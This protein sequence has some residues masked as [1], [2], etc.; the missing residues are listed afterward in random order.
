MRKPLLLCCAALLC[1]TPAAVLASCLGGVSTWSQKTPFAT[2]CSGHSYSVTGGWDITAWTYG[3]S[4]TFPTV[5]GSGS[6]NNLW[7]GYGN[8]FRYRAKVRDA[9]GAK[10]GRWA[11]DVFLLSER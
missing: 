3:G 4:Q 2:A 5:T 8:K 9:K 10:V 7:D 11:W 1:V 6:C